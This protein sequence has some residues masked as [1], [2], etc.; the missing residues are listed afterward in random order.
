MRIYVR[1]CVAFPGGSA[2]GRGSGRGS[3]RQRL[4]RDKLARINE[5]LNHE[6]AAQEAAHT[7]GP[8]RSTSL[9]PPPDFVLQEVS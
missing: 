5:L 4:G 2:G 8:D 3:G 1:V 9:D 7:H 6:E